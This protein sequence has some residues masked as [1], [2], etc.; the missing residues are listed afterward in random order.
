MTD[1]YFFNES[2]SRDSAQAFTN[3]VNGQDN[4]KNGILFLITAGGDPDAAYLIARC[5][6]RHYP[7]G[8]EVAVPFYC[9]SAG[10]LIAIGASAIAL[11][12]GG[13]LGPL[14]V[15]LQRD[16]E[17]A[18]QMSSLVVK[19]SLDA[20]QA[21]AFR[22]FE[23]T[24]L[25]I[26]AKSGGRLN[27]KMAADIA[28]DLTKGLYQPVMEQFD[29][30]RIGEH[31]RSIDIAI[32]YGQRL[33]EKFG[34]LKEDSLE[35]L[36]YGYP[37]H[38]FV[39]DCT[40]SSLLFH[41]VKGFDANLRSLLDRCLMESQ[42]KGSIFALDE[43]GNAGFGEKDAKQRATER[44]NEEAGRLVEPSTS[45]SN[46]EARGLREVSSKSA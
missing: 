25:N 6:Q 20:V 2:I 22:T 12:D 19:Q 7:E 38:G 36:V 28:V 40:E 35:K 46:K 11:A 26:W 3:L 4:A 31:D 21:R 41:R 9:K 5:M 24:F 30:V 15:Q 42:E 34:N 29:P 33:N 18:G 45:G 14:D 8:F 37:S 1:Y 39:I 10:T 43:V 32:Q 13:E 23:Q 27:S 44:Q 17:L 16:N